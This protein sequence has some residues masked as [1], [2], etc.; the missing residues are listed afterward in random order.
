M[1]PARVEIHCVTC[2]LLAWCTCLEQ[3]EQSDEE[4]VHLLAR[5]K[6][7]E[8]VLEEKKATESLLREQL[9]RLQVRTAALFFTLSLLNS[10]L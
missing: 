3:G 6:E 7:L 5:I 9:K 10:E 4:K 8:A 2:N 1:I